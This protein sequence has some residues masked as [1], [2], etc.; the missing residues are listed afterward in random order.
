[1]LKV[2]F[3][4]FISLLLLG[5]NIEEIE[6]DYQEKCD[7]TV[8]DF[9]NTTQSAPNSKSCIIDVPPAV[10]LCTKNSSLSTRD[11]RIFRLS[12]LQFDS[13]PE[14]TQDT[15]MCIKQAEGIYKNLCD[16][17]SHIIAD[18]TLKN[19]MIYRING[20]V[21]VGNGHAE[22]EFENE[23]EKDNFRASGVTLTIE[24]GTHFR[25]SGRGSLIVT[26]G[27]KIIANGTESEPIV[28]SGLD[29]G[30]EGQG[31]WGGLVLHGFAKNNQCLEDST[32]VKCNVLSEDYSGFHGGN[33]DADSSGSI[34]H[35]IIAEAGYEVAPGIKLSGLALNSIGYGTSISN[36]AISNSAGNGIT[37]DGGTVN[38]SNLILINNEENS[39]EWDKGWNGNIQY[40]LMHPR[41]SEI[42]FS[43]IKGGSTAED[44]LELDA[45]PISSPTIS[46][47]T[48]KG[49]TGEKGQLFNFETATQASLLNIVADGFQDCIR[50][51]GMR[52]SIRL[53]NTLIECDAYDISL[54]DYN[55]AYVTSGVSMGDGITN[56]D[57]LI[58]DNIAAASILGLDASNLGNGYVDLGQ[59]HEVTSGNG[60]VLPNTPSSSN[61]STGFFHETDYLGAVSP[62][63]TEST[64]TWF[65]WAQS[66]LP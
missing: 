51:H 15:G 8:V 49:S 6:S 61:A 44:S 11:Q 24:P 5:C 36:V 55:F 31:E 12:P 56:E 7:K 64:N 45:L 16:I 53:E 39:L 26:R 28:M 66:Y 50:I 4:I 2:S 52:N 14:G 22:L 41:H 18:L 43:A 62:N 42:G 48:L 19:D 17:S 1:M 29:E 63:I 13:C 21:T 10:D 23:F 38:A 35:L 47:I 20:Y 3:S 27:S 37:I 65:A 60:I 25:S 30:Y 34:S 59:A 46:N 32:S 9:N 40:A 58:A 54:D 57:V 33:D